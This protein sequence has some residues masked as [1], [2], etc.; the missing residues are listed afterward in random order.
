MADTIQL[1]V[2][3]P[4]RNLV[5]ESVDEVELPGVNGYLGVLPGHA[6]LFSELQ[7]GALSY[8]QA[9]QT[10]LLAVSGGF[11]EVMDN[12]VR[13]LA[14][15]AESARSID[16]ERAKKSRLRAGKRLA[17][18]DASTDYARAQSALERADVRL[19]VAKKN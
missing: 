16:V 2:V 7:T 9:G 13:V 10:H 15:V 4:E 11:V 14:E 6:P 17:E 18:G 5:D 8:R 1:T 3:T 12:A 19:E